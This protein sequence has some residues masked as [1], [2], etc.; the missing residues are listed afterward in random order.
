[1]IEELLFSGFDEVTIGTKLLALQKN[2]DCMI[3]LSPKFC[4]NPNNTAS[5]SNGNA[6]VSGAEGMT[7]KS[8]VVKSDT[9]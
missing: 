9:E 2:S 6:F 5:W 4:S 8:R 3:G 1:M 7:F